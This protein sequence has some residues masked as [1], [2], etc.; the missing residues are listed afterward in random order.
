MN[1][2]LTT[3]IALSFAL[4]VVAQEVRNE[5]P[6]THVQQHEQTTKTQGRMQE[7]GF[8][9]TKINKQQDKV[10]AEKVQRNQVERNTVNPKVERN[11]TTVNKNKTDVNVRNQTNTRVNVQEF[12]TRHREVFNLGRHPKDFFISRYGV[13]HFRLIN[14]TYF[15]F[16]DGCW[17]SVDVDGF[18]Y[19]ERVICQD[20]PEFIVVD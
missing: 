18:T 19:V 14:N 2:I 5:Q 20:D 16:V 15:V 13:N 9:D 6:R 4:P 17:V 11:Q 12:K 1:T 7:R 8:N 10:G 3:I